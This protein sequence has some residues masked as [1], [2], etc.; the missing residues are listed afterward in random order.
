M[1]A[2]EI[3]AQIG[4]LVWKQVEGTVFRVWD[5]VSYHAGLVPNSP[6]LER[7]RDQIMYPDLIGKGCTCTTTLHHAL[8]QIQTQIK[9][10][11]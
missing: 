10:A 7:I 11:G 3:R 5:E 8:E 6:A 4:H 9:E 1:T 2:K